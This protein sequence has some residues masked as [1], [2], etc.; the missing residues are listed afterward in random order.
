MA[1][2]ISKPT[3]SS[4]PA[5]DVSIGLAINDLSEVNSPFWQALDSS[6]FA[7][8][9]KTGKLA[10]EIGKVNYKLS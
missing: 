3:L 10:V 2:S 7:D 5:L 1:P 4:D 8:S 6:S 9:H